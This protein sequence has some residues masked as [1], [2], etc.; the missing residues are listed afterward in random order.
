MGAPF[1]KEELAYIDRCYLEFGFY[2]C[3]DVGVESLIRIGKRLAEGR[4]A[5]LEIGKRKP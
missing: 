5:V 3:K 1:S 4:D 2:R